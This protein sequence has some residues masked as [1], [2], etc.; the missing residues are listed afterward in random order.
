MKKLIYILIFGAV[1]FL[2]YVAFKN[3]SNTKK[4]EDENNQGFKYTDFDST[5]VQGVDCADCIVSGNRGSVV[6]GSGREFMDQN[7]LN[8][9]A[10]AFDVFNIE[11]DFYP[12]IESGYVSKNYLTFLDEK[13]ESTIL[14]TIQRT[15]RAS[16]IS[17]M[18]LDE[19]QEERLVIILKNQ[20]ISRVENKDG[21]IFVYLN[22]DIEIESKIN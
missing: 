5:A 13:G 19:E 16:K 4:I 15:G 8:S 12:T 3:N 11:S 14:E 10:N 22:P 20:G 2:V 17:T 7:F 1:G 9:L 21:F 18:N 6:A